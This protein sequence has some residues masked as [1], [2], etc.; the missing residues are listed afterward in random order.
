MTDRLK[1]GIWV[2]ALIRRCAV[3]NV[4][5]LVVRR[6]DDTGGIVLVKVNRLDGTCTVYSPA[7]AGDGSRLWLKGT[8]PSP[9]GEAD[10]D[11]YI[12]R[13]RSIDPDLWVVEIEDR[14]G[15]HFLLD[16]VE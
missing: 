8:G 14:L 3:E 2:Q 7:R 11:A 13:Q 9:V 6:G 4:P 16:P 15:R 5:A 1:T 10:A 12:G